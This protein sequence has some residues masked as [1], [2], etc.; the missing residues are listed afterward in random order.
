[1]IFLSL[2]ESQQKSPAAAGI[3]LKKVFENAF[4]RF[5]GIG[6]MKGGE[7]NDIFRGDQK[8]QRNGGRA[9][10]QKKEGRGKR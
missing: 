2:I 6:H 3:D 8:I 1:M 4:P 5:A 10:S 9:G 7:E